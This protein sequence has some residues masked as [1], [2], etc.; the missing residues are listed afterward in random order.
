MESGKECGD[1]NYVE[2]KGNIAGPEDCYRLAINEQ[3]CGPFF[4][5][6]HED[7]ECR[8]VN[9]SKTCAFHTDDGTNLYAISIKSFIFLLVF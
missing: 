8:C 4:E 3:R 9:K 7:Y 2:L 6:R 1:S 5:V